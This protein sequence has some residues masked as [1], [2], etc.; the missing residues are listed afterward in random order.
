MIKNKICFVFLD[1]FGGVFFLYNLLI[2]LIWLHLVAEEIA[3][4]FFGLSF[5]TDKM[6]R[7]LPFPAQSP[8]SGSEDKSDS[9][10]VLNN[11]AAGNKVQKADR[12]SRAGKGRGLPKKGT[13]CALF[14][15]A[16]ASL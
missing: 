8:S 3:F 10:V 12:K 1:F 16:V 4:H 14:R 7:L 15:C 5:P 9:E 6:V 2:S 13:H 11:N